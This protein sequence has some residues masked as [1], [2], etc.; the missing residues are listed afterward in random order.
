MSNANE[1]FVTNLFG[2]WGT[3]FDELRGSIG[4]ALAPGCRWEQPPLADTVGP[5]EGMAFLD[6][7]AAAIGLATVDVDMLHMSSTGAVVHT[8]RVD[9]LRRADGSL[10]VSAPVAGVLEIDGDKV[11]AWRE[12]FDA[13]E[14]LKLFAVTG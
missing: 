6:Q 12:Y 3:S 7:A 1:H 5:D 2:R 14:F 11:T 4:D 9:H 8:E 10:I 13:T